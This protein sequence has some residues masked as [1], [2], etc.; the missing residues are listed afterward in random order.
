MFTSGSLIFSVYLRM[1]RPFRHPA[2]IP[3]AVLLVITGKI[4]STRI[5]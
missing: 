1:L 4:I 3:Q 5:F 2:Y